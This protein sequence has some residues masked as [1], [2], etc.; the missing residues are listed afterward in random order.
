M[1]KGLVVK[2]ACI[3]AQSQ[4]LHDKMPQR[5]RA[6]FAV[7]APV[8]PARTVGQD[9]SRFDTLTSV[10]EQIFIPPFHTGEG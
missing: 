2:A 1:Q 10:K 5:R 8:L 4:L 9:P 3:A 7:V 6:Q